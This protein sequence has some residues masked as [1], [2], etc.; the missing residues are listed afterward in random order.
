M[1]DELLIENIK[2]RGKT[3]ILSLSDGRSIIF[4]RTI[5]EEYGLRAGISLREEL[6]EK[7]IRESN[8]RRAMDYALYIL[9]MRGYSSGMLSR[10]MREKGYSPK[11]AG[12]TLA[13]LRR[14]GM[15]DDAL[16]ARQTVESLLR[17]KPAGRP[18]LVAYLQSK[19]IPHRLAAEVVA[20]FIES[21]DETEMAE[22]LLRARWRYLSKFKL[23][24]ARTKAYNYLSRR[25][26]GYRAAKTAF[27]RLMRE[28]NKD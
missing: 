28:E 1:A 22:R 3:L 11:V 5:A 26:I 20:E 23:E 24:T 25:S 9:S 27:D 10:K 6:I 14:M 18:F 19:L 12:Q 21:A 13:E 17:R 4:S 2:K 15:L 7:L 8:S 16:F